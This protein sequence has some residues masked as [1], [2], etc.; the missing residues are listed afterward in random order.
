MK[1][2]HN[3][4]NV[5]R[6]LP[7]N[8]Y[9]GTDQLLLSRG[10]VIERESQLEGLLERGMY[11]DAAELE[12]S[13]EKAQ[14]AKILDPFWAWDDLVAKLGY[15]LTRPSAELGFVTRIKDIAQRVM[16]LTQ[17]HA[18]AT[19]AIIMLTMDQRRYP[20]VHCLQTAVLCDLVA[21]R[22]GWE[23]PRRGSLICAALTMNIGMHELQQQLTNQRTPLTPE[24]QDLV[25]QHPLLGADILRQA[26]V[27]SPI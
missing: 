20:T 1:L 10:F 25:K 5:G 12:A 13:L 14:A 19:I 27:D 4:L 16:L 6:P 15:Q 18:D 22:L 2:Q 17:R 3:H 23:R 26:G 8:V 11:V 24:Q 21:T 9:D 7:W